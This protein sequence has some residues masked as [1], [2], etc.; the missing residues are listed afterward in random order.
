MSVMT[1]PEKATGLSQPGTTMSGIGMSGTGMSGAG[2]SGAGTAMSG[3]GLSGT[4]LSGAGGPAMPGSPLAGAPMPGQAGGGSMPGQAG[5]GSMPAPPPGAATGRGA[6][7]EPQPAETRRLPVSAS[8]PAPV[9]ALLRARWPWLVGTALAGTVAGAALGGSSAVQATAQ[10]RVVGVSDSIRVRQLGQTYQ[11]LATARAVLD[12]A[13]ASKL[14]ALKGRDARKIGNDI[15]ATYSLDTDLVAITATNTSPDV[16]AAEATAVARAVVSYAGQVRD[17]QL[18]DFRTVANSLATNQKLDNSSAEIQRLQQ[19]GT[20][21]ANGQYIALQDSFSIAV[22]T[23]PDTVDKAGVSR[24]VTGGLGGVGGLM[25]GALVATGVGS[26][27]RR[28]RNPG[29]LRALAPELRL[30]ST[31]QAGEVAGR[32]LESGHSTLVVLSLPSTP[33]SA[34]RFAAA[35]ANHLRT[36]GSSVTLVNAIALEANESATMALPDEVWVLRRDIRA[37]VPAY[38]ATD[39]LVVACTAEPEAVGL[40][41]GQ[42]DLMTVVVAKEGRSTVQ[43]IWDAVSAVESTD[44]LV[45]LAP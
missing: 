34:S 12:L 14:S 17:Q 28:A 20:Q 22:A 32:L 16:A 39:M 18:N 21:V 23:V 2:M 43:Q 38:F 11:Q 40:I 19:V 8:R 10:L 30:R 13:A 37:D 36:H 41:S 7:S 15:K 26:G 9:L 44:P 6:H 4:D 29:E 45:V 25:L 42:S 24:Q 33:S 31:T 3:P 5:G 27:R 1:P 35:V